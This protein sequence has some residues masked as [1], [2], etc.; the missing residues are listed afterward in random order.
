MIMK[1]SSYKSIRGDS[2]V[3]S[4]LYTLVIVINFTTVT[5]ALIVQKVDGAIHRINHCPA[6]KHKKN[7]L[8]YL[9]DSSCMSSTLQTTG[10][11]WSIVP[12][13]TNKYYEPVSLSFCDLLKNARGSI[14]LSPFSFSLLS[15]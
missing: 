5:M 15:F 6:N 9:V 3:L 7:Q 13:S 2:I 10:A 11:T 1:C 4:F 12:F 14:K 8:S